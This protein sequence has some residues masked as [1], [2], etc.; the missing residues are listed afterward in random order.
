MDKSENNAMAI[1]AHTENTMADQ[2]KFISRVTNLSTK[3]SMETHKK[4]TSIKKY[5]TVASRE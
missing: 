4:P 5:N 2:N 1:T 3:H